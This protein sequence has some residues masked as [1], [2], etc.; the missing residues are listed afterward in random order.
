MKK[1]ERNYDEKCEDLA[2][3]FYPGASED[4]IIDLAND[5]QSQAESRRDHEGTARKMNADCV[6]CGEPCAA[7]IDAQ[8]RRVE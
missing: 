7:D 2:R 6:A 3:Y 4:F 8:A 1:R 5:L